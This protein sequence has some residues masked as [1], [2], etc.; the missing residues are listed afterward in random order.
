MYMYVYMYIHAYK[1]PRAVCQTTPPGSIHPTY[2]HPSTTGANA[3]GVW[4][5]MKKASEV[6]VKKIKALARPVSS[7]ED[8]HNIATI[9]S[10]SPIMVGNH[11]YVGACVKLWGVLLMSGFVGGRGR[12]SPSPSRLLMVLICACPH[13]C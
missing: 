10:G 4:R 13:T 8:L 2:P 3:I 5:G 12:S 9:A 11:F 6:L 1:R 7:G